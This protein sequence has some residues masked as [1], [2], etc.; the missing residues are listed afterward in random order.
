MFWLKVLISRTA[1][2]SIKYD[3]HWNPRYGCIQR[4]GRID[5]IGSEHEVIFA[6]K[7]SCGGNRRAMKGSL[8]F[9]VRE[10]YSQSHQEIHDTIGEDT[11]I[12]ER[13]ERD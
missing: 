13:N 10:D 12:L 5:R 3:L 11:N 4:F 9:C 1:T 8:G 2:T 6:H 7:F